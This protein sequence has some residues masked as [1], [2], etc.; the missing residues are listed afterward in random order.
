MSGPGCPLV[1]QEEADGMVDTNVEPGIIAFANDAFYLAFNNRD[2]SQMEALWASFHPCVCIHPGWGPLFGRDDV[3]ESW[4]EIFE[5]QSDDFRVISHGSRVLPMGDVHAVVCYEQL[6]GGWLI[7]TNS[8][9]MEEGE[10]RLVH[11]QASQCAP[12][13]GLTASVP[14]TLQ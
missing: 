4:Q 2:F 12:P 14:Q 8:F 7:A 5:G 10:P 1:S 9:V 6:P 11:H 3:L 13:A